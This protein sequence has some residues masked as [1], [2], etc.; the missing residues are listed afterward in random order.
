ML[1]PFPHSN[2]PEML[3]LEEARALVLSRAGI[4]LPE[5]VSLLKVVGRVSANHLVSDVDVCAFAHAAMDGFALRH[6]E[7]AEASE[8]NPV[9]LRV[10]VEIA[11]GD[12]FTGSVLPG[13]CVRIM[14]GAPIPAGLDVVVQYEIVHTV[15]GDGKTGSLVS[16]NSPVKA[17]KNIREAAEEVAAGSVIVESGEVISSAG[18]GF[19]ASCGVTEVTT[20]R[21]PLVAV[22]P[23]GSELI[24]PTEKPYDGKIRSSN[25]YTIAACV[26][27][28]GGV[29]TTMPIVKDSFEELRE[30]VQKA[31]QNFDVVVVM[32]GASGGDYDFIKPVVADLG[33]LLMTNVNIQ[34]GK[35]QIFGLVEKV[36][37][38]GLPGNP[39]AAYLGFEML[40]RPLLRKMQG[41]RHF[42]RPRVK[43]RLAQDVKK[44][45][46]RRIFMRSSLMKDA[47]GEYLVVPAKNQ[48][49]EL[50]GVIQ[51]SNCLAILP[52][53]FDLREKGSLVECLLLDVSEELGL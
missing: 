37:V 35:G 8:Q 39:A 15:E 5:T 19:L 27:A 31:A 45:D 14:T 36:P 6:T 25:E 1:S 43:A 4:M 41:Y 12:F 23:V 40:V 13:E 34:P 22:I 20:F 49:S 7:I 30:A 17:R 21:H 32:G 16:F 33:E 53:G 24:N 10:I 46:A 51:R 2:K 48:S 42:E 18:V 47:N 44:N 50:F 11:A 26:Q 3:S 52:E 9:V 38:F 28:A 29:P